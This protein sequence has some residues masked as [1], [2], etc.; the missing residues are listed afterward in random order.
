MKGKRPVE[1][2]EKYPLKD[3]EKALL[4]A[5]MQRSHELQLEAN[6]ALNGIVAANGLTGSWTYN[7]AGELQKVG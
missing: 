4:Q 7:G 3:S 5:Y 6:G 1:N 2:E